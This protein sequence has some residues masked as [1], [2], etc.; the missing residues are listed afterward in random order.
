MNCITMVII[1]NLIVLYIQNK[2]NKTI[3][4][5]ILLFCYTYDIIIYDKLLYMEV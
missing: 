4:L 1:Y 2:C 5:I 3:Y